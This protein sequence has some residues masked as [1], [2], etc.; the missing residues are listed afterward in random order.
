MSFRR[1]H[2]VVTAMLAAALGAAIWISV[3][4][5][6]DAEEALRSKTQE[7]A[8]L[9]KRAETAEGNSKLV[10]ERFAEVMKAFANEAG[11][12]SGRSLRRNQKSFV[13]I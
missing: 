1:I 8:L 12:F 7:N 11:H 3:R 6:N 2:F 4:E 10:V 9:R 5:R 13:Q